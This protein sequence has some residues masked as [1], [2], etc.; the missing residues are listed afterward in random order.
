MANFLSLSR[1][2]CVMFQ[3]TTPK[4]CTPRFHGNNILYTSFGLPA[5]WCTICLRGAFLVHKSKSLRNCT[6]PV[7]YHLSSALMVHTPGLFIQ[8]LSTIFWVQ[9][10]LDHDRVSIYWITYTTYLSGLLHVNIH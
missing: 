8:F 4:S 10:G 3:Y 1:N 5:S 6:V 2:H 7:K 9:S